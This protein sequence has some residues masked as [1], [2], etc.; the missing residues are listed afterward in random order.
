[1]AR[2]RLT[3]QNNVNLAAPN[4]TQGERDATQ[5]LARTEPHGAAQRNYKGYSGEA[6]QWRPVTYPA[7]AAAM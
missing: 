6:E 7:A 1:V 5:P 3:Q 4:R 2:S